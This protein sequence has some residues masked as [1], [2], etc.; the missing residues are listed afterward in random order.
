MQTL[1]NGNASSIQGVTDARIADIGSKA[2]GEKAQLARIRQY[3]TNPRIV[4]ALDRLAT[5][6]MKQIYLVSLIILALLSVLADSYALAL[7]MDIDWMAW[8]AFI[9]SG[10]DDMCDD[11]RTACATIGADPKRINHAWLIHDVNWQYPKGYD[12]LVRRFE[13]AGESIW[14][15]IGDPFDQLLTV[16]ESGA[17]GVDLSTYLSL[18]LG[19]SIR[20]WD[21]FLYDVD[22]NHGEKKIPNLTTVLLLC[23][24]L[25]GL[26]GFAR[27]WKKDA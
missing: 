14:P 24:G 9:P 17:S 10:T 12:R 5:I 13:E 6:M 7:T 21:Y 3:A 18:E 15:Y 16:D 11:K 27:K 20:R 2:V 23:F 25:I 26:A 22:R 1:T 19:Q 8:D 4:I